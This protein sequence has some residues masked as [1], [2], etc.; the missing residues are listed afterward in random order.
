MSS[1]HFY[2]QTLSLIH[3]IKELLP[4]VFNEI[5]HLRSGWQQAVRI[6]LARAPEVRRLFEYN[7]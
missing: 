3:F 2:L 5:L 7:L 4:L 1:Q 6:L